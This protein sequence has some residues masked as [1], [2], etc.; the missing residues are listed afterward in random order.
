MKYTLRRLRC[1]GKV[2]VLRFCAREMEVDLDA[3]RA[4]TARDGK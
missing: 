1:F 2:A 3:K 4:P